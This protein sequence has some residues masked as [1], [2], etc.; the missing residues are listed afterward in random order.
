MQSAARSLVVVACLLT[1]GCNSSRVGTVS[2]TFRRPDRPFSPL[3]LPAEDIPLSDDAEAPRPVA[4][5]PER[6]QIISTDNKAANK[7][8]VADDRDEP[9]EVS[10]RESESL[11]R[12]E[13]T[14]VVHELTQATPSAG[15]GVVTIDGRSYE[16]RLVN[17]YGNPPHKSS[18]HT[19]TVSLPSADDSRMQHARLVSD[20][21]V[22]N[23]DMD[24]A[25]G[26]EPL[27]TAAPDAVLINLPTALSMVSGRHPAVAFARW[28]VQEAYAQ[29]D[30]AEVLWLPA[31][32]AGF[33]FHRHDGNYQ[34]SN[35]AIV[36]VNRN[37]FQ[38]GFG[39]GATG[40][41]TT[42]QPGLRAQFHL[43]DAIFQPNI[44]RKTAWA[45]GHAENAV[46]NRQMRD[47][48]LAYTALLDATQQLRIL[49][50]SR[51]RVA[52]VSRLTDDFAA[53]G[54]GLQADADRMQTE[55]RLIDGRVIESR[56]SVD[57]A[58]ARLAHALS[59][60]PGKRIVAMDSAVV[61]LEL[62]S[63][64]TDASGLIRSGLSAR[65]ELKELQALVAAACEQHRRQRFAPFV[66]SVLLGAGTSG[67]GGGVGDS[68][69]NVDDRY[70]FDAMVTWEVRNLGFGERAARREAQAQV[71][72]A[73]YRK[74][75][76][77]DDV[78]RE[79]SEAQT[80][81]RHRRERMEMTQKAIQ[82]ARDSYDRNLGRI[83][84]GQGLPLEVLQSVRALEEAS[85]AYASSVTAYNQSQFQ[86][87]WALGWPVQ[88][89]P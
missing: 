21:E 54:Q 2:S 81:V 86:L 57:L 62:V 35:G 5:S 19:S 15:A 44:A 4:S 32:Q 64:E 12:L 48:A 23:V 34:A 70:D 71:Q 30:Q 80:Q 16:I 39:A 75:R 18:L 83:R 69:N 59:S 40:A 74:V 85:L 76:L 36:D 14:P 60:N 66:P 87:Q 45:R 65:P 3:P 6:I 47:V 82:T 38:Y 46:V 53:A 9:D 77:M 28:R 72:Q 49:E 63:V 24:E 29:L 84:D 25:E 43:A 41:G 42:P 10:R 22:V 8:V 11:P 1:A 68:L 78:A 67:F 17:P 79:I 7:A 52:A 56:E 89:S 27:P 20:A 50:E 13:I 58:S 73:M 37:S 51:A 55:L 33:S 31:L 26:I 88:A 61:P